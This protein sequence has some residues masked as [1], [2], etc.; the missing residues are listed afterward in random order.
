M[1]YLSITKCDQLNYEGLRVVLWVAGC[2]HGC[3]GCQNE[4]SQNPL[5]GI[6]FD[7]AAEDEIFEEL[8][9][10]WCTGLTLSGGD[11]LYPD[12]RECV[13]DFARRVKEKFPEKT[14]CLYTGYTWGEIV[15][16]DG[17]KEIL[18][19][20]DTIIDGEYVESLRSVELPWVGS[21]NQKII[22]VRERLRK[23]REIA[24]AADVC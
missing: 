19:Y 5:A 6:P 20:V 17:M 7:K 2:C 12:N 22:D 3:K 16:D 14:I 24:E 10:D 1:N 9:K 15:A 11:P 23:V 4:F 21:S 8:G 13:I 18:R